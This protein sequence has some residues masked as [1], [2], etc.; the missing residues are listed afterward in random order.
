[1][2]DQKNQNDWENQRVL[3]R[4]RI[5]PRAYFVP[6]AEEK[7]ALTSERGKSPWFKLLNGNWKFHLAANPDNAPADFFDEATSVAD[8]DDIHDRIPGGRF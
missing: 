3:E 2:T 1:M 6:F 7:S 8:W 5:R 4:N